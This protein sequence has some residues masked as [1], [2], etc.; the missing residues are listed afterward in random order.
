MSWID[1]IWIWISDH[2]TV[3]STVITAIATGF[4]AWF[5]VALVRVTKQTARAERPWIFITTPS[6][7][8]NGGSMNPVRGGEWIDFSIANHG[9]VPGIIDKAYGGMSLGQEPELP[10]I[11]EQFY[12][13]IGPDEKMEKCL[14]SVP[15]DALSGIPL[16]EELFFYV[17]IIY[18]GISGVRYETSACWSYNASIDGWINYGSKK[19][20]Y[21][22]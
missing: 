11:S 4:L 12:G 20:N 17:L 1:A 8:L 19:Y 21:V 7:I 14:S 5:T 13:V 9:R 16:G 10:P 6:G 3:L 18:T 2:T 22:K 15:N